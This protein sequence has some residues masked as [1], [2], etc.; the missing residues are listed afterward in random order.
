M[1]AGRKEGREE[2][3]RKEERKGEGKEGRKERIYEIV[4]V[5]VERSTRL[6]HVG[7]LGLF[8]SS[9]LFLHLFTL[10]LEDFFCHFFLSPSEN[11]GKKCE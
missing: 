10:S 4:L 7:L 5:I 6:L 2:G 3:G 1:Q 8:F 9:S 11:E